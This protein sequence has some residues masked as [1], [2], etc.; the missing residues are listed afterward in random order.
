MSPETVLTE[1]RLG[2]QLAMTLGGPLLVAVLVV[3]IV[4][5][6]VQA[7]T[8]INEPTIAFVAKAAVLFAV[9]AAGG[10]WLLGTLVD[11]TAALIQRIPE[12][13]G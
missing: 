11:F 13:V 5:G 10:S 1:L 8:Q 7:A 2:M 9:V 6:I 3:G 12:L 4:V